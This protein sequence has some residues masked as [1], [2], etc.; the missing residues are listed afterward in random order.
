[1]HL[2]W[3]KMGENPLQKAINLAKSTDMAILFVGNTR[4][5]ETEGME[6]F[7]VAL[8]LRFEDAENYVMVLKMGNKGSEL[9]A[10]QT[11]SMRRATKK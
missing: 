9:K 1:M 2:R 7:S 11:M 6:G 3:Q 8:T 10:C 5:E 4:D